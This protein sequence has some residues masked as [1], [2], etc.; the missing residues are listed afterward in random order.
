MKEELVDQLLIA[1]GNGHY[2]YKVGFIIIESDYQRIME[3]IRKIY[4]PKD[5]E[6][7]HGDTASG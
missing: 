6:G 5:K 7:K 3:L 4:Q 2:V 1:L